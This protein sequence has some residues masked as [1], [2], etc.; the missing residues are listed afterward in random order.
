MSDVKKIALI[1]NFN[2]YEKAGAAMQVAQR[3]SAYPCEV[4]VASFNRDKVLRMNRGRMDFTFLP[5]DEMYANADLLI[6]LGG[7]GTILEAARRSAVR[8]TPILGINLGRVGY[9]A[10]LEM[11]ELDMLSHLFDRVTADGYKPAEYFTETRSMLHVEVV[12]TEGEVRQRMYG[13]NDAVITNGSVSRIVDIELSENGNP[14]TTYRA[15][16]LIV[17]TPTGS[18]A[19]SMSA[20]GPVT[21]PRVKCF[22]VTPICPHSLAAR[23]MIFPDDS[24]LEIRNICQREKMLYLTVDG[25]TNCELYR[26]E[27]VRITRSPLETRLIR[28][29]SCGFYNRLRLKMA[30]HG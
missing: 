10:E 26:G 29:K 5:M 8:Q 12:N 24:V 7:D 15:D 17:A 25:R 3:L 14:V 19:Y 9:M 28:L 18:T 6:V 27:V 16:G 22:C 20:G 4:M 13:L 11:G 21:D 30:E 23:P 2:I 1:T